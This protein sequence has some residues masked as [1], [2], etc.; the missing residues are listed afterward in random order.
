MMQFFLTIWIFMTCGI[1]YAWQHKEFQPKF[2][3]FAAK[4]TAIT[5]LKKEDNID[6]LL[7]DISK[8]R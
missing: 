1:K 7:D 3:W 5:E 4:H 2:M 8:R 6:C